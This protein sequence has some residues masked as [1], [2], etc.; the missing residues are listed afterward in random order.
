[1]YNTRDSSHGAALA[2]AAAL[3]RERRALVCTNY[4]VAE[5]H[6]VL[7][8]RAGYRIALDFLMGIDRSEFL[9]ERAT[10]EDEAAAKEIVRRHSDKPLSFV[11]ATSFAV[12][13][14]LGIAEAFTFDSDFQQYGFQSARP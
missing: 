6:S 4:V 1:M 9:Q 12:M 2:I 13:E 7:L 11:D 5:T 8:G 14:R 3:N 10:L